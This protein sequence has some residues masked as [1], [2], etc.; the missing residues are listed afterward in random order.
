MD[1]VFHICFEKGN[2]DVN[3]LTVAE[4]FCRGKS[5]WTLG[6]SQILIVFIRSKVF[7]VAGIEKSALNGLYFLGQFLK[8]YA[9]GVVDGAQNGVPMIKLFPRL[10]LSVLCDRK[11]KL[12]ALF[13]KNCMNQ[14]RGFS[15]V[16]EH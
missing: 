16:V 5:F 2:P 9:I 4:S 8:K 1:F 10:F 13:S 3:F 6:S 11:R 7:W 14:S 15:K 12:L